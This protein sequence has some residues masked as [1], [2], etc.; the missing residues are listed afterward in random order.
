MDDMLVRKVAF[1]LALVGLAVLFG[2]LFF[3]NEPHDHAEPSPLEYV[4]QSTTAKS[5]VHFLINGIA[6]DSS[7]DELHRLCLL[8]LMVRDTFYDGLVAFINHGDP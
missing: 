6:I 4:L 3:P 1:G 5:Y 8:L 2:I 7:P